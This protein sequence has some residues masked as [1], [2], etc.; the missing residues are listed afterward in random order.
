MNFEL[1]L[2]DLKYDKNRHKTNQILLVN[3]SCFLKIPSPCCISKHN[4]I[5]LPPLPALSLPLP[6]SAE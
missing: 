2:K 5:A 6:K 4:A 3:H 1:V